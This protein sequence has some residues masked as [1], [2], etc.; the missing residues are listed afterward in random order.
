MLRKENC[1][2]KAPEHGEEQEIGFWLYSFSH[3]NMYVKKKTV[4]QIIDTTFMTRVLENIPKIN[5]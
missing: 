1:L 3:N 2:S 4:L 5:L